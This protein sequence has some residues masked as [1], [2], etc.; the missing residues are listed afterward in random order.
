[1]FFTRSLRAKTLL[2][3]LIP[4]APGLLAVATIALYAYE[5]VAQDVVKQ[6]DAALARLQARGRG[7]WTTILLSAVFFALIHSPL[8]WPFTF[9]YGVVTGYY[10]IRERNLLPLMM[11]HAIVDFWSF[12]WFLLLR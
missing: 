7:R 1:M 6:R 3:V 12:G 5:R 4:T 8:H 2:Y 9:L 11:T 10:Y